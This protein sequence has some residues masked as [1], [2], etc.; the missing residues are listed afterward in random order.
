MPSESKN[1][2]I[3]L[4]I[5]SKVSSGEYLKL[6]FIN[7]LSGVTLCAPTPPFIFVICKEVGGK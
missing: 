3:S 4:L 5:S 1:S 7:K 2:I 6:N